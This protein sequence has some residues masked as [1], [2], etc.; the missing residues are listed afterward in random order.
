MRRIREVAVSV[1]VGALLALGGCAP[2]G[3]PGG[4]ASPEPESQGPHGAVSSVH[5]DVMYY[6]ACGNETLD[7]EGTM[8]FPFSSDESETWATPVAMADAAPGGLGGGFARVAL[9]LP[10][11]AAPGPGDDIGTLTIYEDGIAYWVSE[12]GE[13]D[14]WLTS[15]PLEYNWVC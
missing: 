13:L 8:W 5:E 6:P 12:N 14:T 11:V 7:Y 3:N 9:R 4:P 2:G 10:T 1:M 15:T